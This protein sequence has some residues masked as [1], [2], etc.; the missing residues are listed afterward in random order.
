[1][2]EENSTEMQQV[3]ERLAKVERQNRWIVRGGL[4]LVLLCGSVL[5]IAAHKPQEPAAKIIEAQG[6][7][8]RDA[9]GDLKA[10]LG[11]TNS[12]PQLMLYGSEPA[13]LAYLDVDKNGPSLVLVSNLGA[14]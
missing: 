4:G 7:V 13:T 8:L 3:M 14:C 6:F 5:L 12:G 11:M 10:T 9:A 1:M 2:M